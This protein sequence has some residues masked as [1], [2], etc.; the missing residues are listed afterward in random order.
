MVKINRIYTKTGDDG[1]TGL[2]GGARVS[3]DCSRVQAYGEVD[4]LNAC[5]G[6]AI[7][8]AEARGKSELSQRL[9]RI[10]NELFDLGA[11]LA[12]PAG[13]KKADLS[14]TEPQIKQLETW[15]D[16]ISD[17]LPELRSFVLPG[18]TELNARLHLCRT[19]CRRAERSVVGLSKLEKDA[20]DPIIFRYLNRLSDFLFAASRKAAEGKEVLWE[21]GKTRK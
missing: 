12:T 20:V 8:E 14:I 11:E 7:C 10:Q 16:E 13:K 9:A 19:V 2:V 18:G 3:K 5:I 4:E 6:L 15:I 1:T 21:P 17:Q